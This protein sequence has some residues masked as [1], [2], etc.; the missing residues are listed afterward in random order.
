M[1]QWIEEALLHEQAKDIKYAA[2][3]VS[4]AKRAGPGHGTF[5]LD[6]ILQRKYGYGQDGTGEGATAG[7]DAAA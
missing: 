3:L 2:N 7:G 5:H 6:L 1:C 4:Q